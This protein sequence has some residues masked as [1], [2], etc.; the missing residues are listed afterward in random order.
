MSV[1]N[2]NFFGRRDDRLVRIFL[3]VAIGVLSVIVFYPQIFGHHDTDIHN[4]LLSVQEMSQ[5]WQ[6]NLYSIFYLLVYVLSFGTGNFF[7]ISCAA[8]AVLTL[9]VV[10]KGLLSYS[11]MKNAVGR[12]LS[13]AFVTIALVLIMPLPNWWKPEQIYL[14]KIAP[15]FWFNSTSILTMPFAILLFF[16]ALSWLRTLSLRSW[17][18]LV[19]FSLLS[20]LTK[21]NY[22]LAFMPALGVAVLVRIAVTKSEIGRALLLFTGLALLLIFVLGLQYADTYTGSNEISSSGES[23][24]IIIAPFAVWKLYS[25]NI[26]ASLLLS[27][28]FPL[29][30]AVFYFPEIKTDPAV[31]LAWAVWTI[32]VLQYVF[33]AESGE[34]LPDGNWGWG[35][36]I[37]IY[38]VFLVSA[39]VFLRQPRSL[40][41]YLVAILFSLH[42]AT[43]IYYFAKIAHGVGFL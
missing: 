43:G 23:T 14:D 24:H 25:P 11:A 6:Y 19:T 30:V 40:R 36:N 38:I 8:M 37:A 27:I 34:F 10:A 5:T 28:A 39:M 17:L 41:Y 13:A 16:S 3:A 15:N 21:P 22:V 4:H 2:T 35:S 31:L 7:L 42:L 32:A 1:S 33:L 18:W 20:V 9:S 26:P 29:S 12:R